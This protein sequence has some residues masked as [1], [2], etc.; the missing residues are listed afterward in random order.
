MNKSKTGLRPALKL[1]LAIVLALPG[2]VSAQNVSLN[3]ER[4]SSLEK[5][6]A[7]QV[8]DFTLSASGVM[9][10]AVVHNNENNRTGESFTANFQLQAA[11]QLTNRW[12]VGVAYFGQYTDENTDVSVPDSDYVDNASVSVGSSWGTFVF[13]NV[14][15][16]VREQTRRR[17][18]A[19]SGELAFD[20]FLGEPA[21]SGASYVGRFG[22]W[23]VSSIYD[24]DDQYDF[25]AVYQRPRGTKDYR[26]T[27][28]TNKAS[29]APSTGKARHD[30]KGIG[31]VGELIYGS[32]AFDIGMGAERVYFDGE[33]MKRR[34]AS[35]GI[36]NKIGALTLSAEGHYGRIA[37]NAEKSTALG[38]QYDMA[39]GLSVNLGVNY[40]ATQF[41]ADGQT[42][43][44]TRTK[45]TIVSIR[46]SF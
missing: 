37:G 35:A 25:G 19:G 40:A 7:T 23:V 32:T 39:R 14:A 18:G 46:Y 15:A 22:P 5:P 1:M 24:E 20:D 38:A 29:Y 30:T 9:D 4:L 11:A 33:T 17:R 10:S 42:I 21:D 36:R 41:S 45:S 2:A 44:R 6:L 43:E 8:G 13:G 27:F 28:R 26:L 31:I 3:S 16:V 34:Y 12:H